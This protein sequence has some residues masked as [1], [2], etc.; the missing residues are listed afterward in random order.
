MRKFVMTNCA[1]KSYT[2]LG[3][4]IPTFTAELNLIHLMVVLAELASVV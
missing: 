4:G 3:V 2:T 1:K